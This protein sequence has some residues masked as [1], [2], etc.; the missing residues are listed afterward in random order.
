[1][2]A[3]VGKNSGDISFF[4]K[5]NICKLMASARFQTSKAKEDRE[6]HS[7]RPLFCNTIL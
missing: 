5:K 2:E 1:M 4:D 3:L 7:F 6:D